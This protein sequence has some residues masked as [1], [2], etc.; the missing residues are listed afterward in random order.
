MAS[1]NP[2]T[3]A[4]PDR[5]HTALLQ[6]VSFTQVCDTCYVI[7]AISIARPHGKPINITRCNKPEQNYE[8][9]VGQCMYEKEGLV[10]IILCPHWTIQ[11]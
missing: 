4:A 7:T 11:R 8:F 2:L 3:S 9:E 5:Q 6:I 10:S 1:C